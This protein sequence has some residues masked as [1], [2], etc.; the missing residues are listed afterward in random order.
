MRMIE[1]LPSR[2]RDFLRRLTE[3]GRSCDDRAAVQDG[4]EFD[5]HC[6]AGGA[7]AAV[8]SPFVGDVFRDAVDA[9]APAPGSD[10]PQMGLQ[11]ETSRPPLHQEGHPGSGAAPGSGE[12]DLGLSADQRRAR[13]RRRPGAAQHGA[14]HPQ[15]C[16]AGSRT[17]AQCAEHVRF[18]IRDR[19]ARMHRPAP[20]LQRTPPASRTRR[21]RPALQPASPSSGTMPA[22]TTTD[23]GG[24]AHRPRQGPAQAR[25]SPRRLDQRVQTRGVDRQKRPGQHPESSIRTRHGR[26]GAGRAA[27]VGC[28]PA[29]SGKSAAGLFFPRERRRGWLHVSRS[30]RS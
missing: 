24:G 8:A 7:L 19:A 4:A 3:A 23:L 27:S 10:R 20:H 26:A 14:G 16:R 28:S 15:R 29:G 21:V 9:P 6:P 18:L 25:G 12:P 30:V 1:I 17:P 22:T 11:E 13:R 2:V 5:L